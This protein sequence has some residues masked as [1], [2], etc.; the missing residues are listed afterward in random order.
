LALGSA[1]PLIQWVP[2]DISPG[3]KR[4][5]FEADH[6]FPSNPCYVLVYSCML[7]LPSS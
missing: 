1:Q 3:V 2:G 6:S 5:G 4:Q 7:S